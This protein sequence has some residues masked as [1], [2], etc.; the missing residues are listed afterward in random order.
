MR[1]LHAQFSIMWLCDGDFN[2]VYVGGEEH[3]GSHERE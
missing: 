3:F 1:F 2:E